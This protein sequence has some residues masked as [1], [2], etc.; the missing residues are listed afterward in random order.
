[1]DNKETAH[2]GARIPIDLFNK[3]EQTRKDL[4]RSRNYMIEAALKYYLDSIEGI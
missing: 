4:N 2:V 3:L 1:M